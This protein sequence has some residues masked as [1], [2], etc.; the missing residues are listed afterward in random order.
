ML[1]L[2]ILT[3]GLLPWIPASLCRV[4]TEEE[5]IVLEGG[6]LTIPCHYE[7][8]YAGHVKYWCQG[9]TREFCTT[10]ARTDDTGPND[11]AEDK[12]SVFDDPAQQVFTVTMNKLK[13]GDSG[14]Y[15][16][17][18]E[19]GSVWN[20]DDV[21]FTNIKVVHAASTTSPPA[22][23]QSVVHLPPPKP[24]TKES[25]NSHSRMLEPIV[26]CSSLML[27]VALAILGRKLW[28][29]HKVDPVRRQVKDIKAR[30]NEY[31]G[32]IRYCSV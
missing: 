3:L 24:I 26:V 1:Q 17:G 2:Y 6:S 27:L 13:V 30:F 22:P 28:K 32:D 15:M 4:N 5:F 29:L 23:Q 14:W 18:V 20:A 21:A 31:P 19:I 25:W 11:P 9:T 7:R 8:Q 16:C 12:V 10:L